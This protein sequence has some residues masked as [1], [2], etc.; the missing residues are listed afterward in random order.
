MKTLLL[1]LF[2]IPRMFGIFPFT[3][4][5]DFGLHN[6]EELGVNELFGFV[7]VGKHDSEIMAFVVFDKAD[8]KGFSPLDIGETPLSYVRAFGINH[9][10]TDLVYGTALDN[11]NIVVGF[12][13]GAVNYSGNTISGLGFGDETIVESGMKKVFVESDTHSPFVL[14]ETYSHTCENDK[15]YQNQLFHTANI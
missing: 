5:D 12:L 9:G 8:G 10:D 4:V 2:L 6:I 1:I 7:G 15:Q 14:A 11:G 3:M 13:A